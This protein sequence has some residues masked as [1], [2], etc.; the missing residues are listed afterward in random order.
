MALPVVAKIIEVLSVG[1]KQASPW[2]LIAY[3]LLSLY[4]L[5]QVVW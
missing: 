2:V 3:A 1:V 5:T 4:I